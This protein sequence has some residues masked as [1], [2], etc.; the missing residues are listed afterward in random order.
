M[1]HRLRF[2]P[3]LLEN[4][5]SDEEWDE[6]CIELERQERIRRM[7]FILLDEIVNGPVE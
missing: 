4:V 2:K 6:H 1:G 5:F 3:Y 7:T